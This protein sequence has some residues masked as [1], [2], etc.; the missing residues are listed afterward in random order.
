MNVTRFPLHQATFLALAVLAPL[1]AQGQA[2]V[3]E[4]S[5]AQK[6]AIAT[7]PTFLFRT[8][9]LSPEWDRLADGRHA[10]KISVGYTEPFLGNSMSLGVSV[11]FSSPTS[12]ADT[13]FLL[14]HTT[15]LFGSESLKG[16]STPGG[17]SAS[18]DQSTQSIALG[19]ILLKLQWIP[20]VTPHHG[21]LL[22]TSVS[23]PTSGNDLVGSGKWTITPSVAYAR[24]W[25]PRL[26]VAQFFQQ[27]TSFAGS[28][29]R[30]Q[31]NRSDLDLY[32]VYSGRSLLWWVTSD[33]NLGIDEANHNKTPA[34]A[35]I[36]YGRGLRRM[37]GGSLNGSVQAGAGIGDDRPYNV[38]VSAGISLVGIR[39]SR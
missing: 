8:L 16:S 1:F 17:G 18:D 5:V 31:V 26:L 32:M 25:G 13:S 12:A 36:S 23:L 21:V 15:N 24:F 10:T 4:K 2:A 28:E 7:N 27:Q 6:P 3:P 35:T 33:L 11:P 37:F 19:D 38:M 22:T 9:S 34:S 29:R 14:P 39:R 30:T 20:Y